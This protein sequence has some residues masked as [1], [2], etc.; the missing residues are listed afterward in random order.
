MRTL[1][2]GGQSGCPRYRIDPHSLAIGS[3]IKL[4]ECGLMLGTDDLTYDEGQLR[5]YSI[6]SSNF[7]TFQTIVRLISQFESILIPL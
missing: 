5:I 4:Y 2:G 7:F 3:A 6:E 1:F